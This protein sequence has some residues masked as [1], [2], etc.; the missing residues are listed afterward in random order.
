MFGNEVKRGGINLVVVV[1][2]NL[3]FTKGSILAFAISALQRKGWDFGGFLANAFRLFSKFWYLLINIC[4]YGTQI[5]TQAVADF[6]II[7]HVNW[8][9]IGSNWFSS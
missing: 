3:G 4:Y 8:G 9:E 1:I 7:S 5:Y 6:L 2:G